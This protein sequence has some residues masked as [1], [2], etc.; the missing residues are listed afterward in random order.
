M[1]TGQKHFSYKRKQLRP[2]SLL[3]R[4]P[5]NLLIFGLCIS[6]AQNGNLEAKQRYIVRKP[7]KKRK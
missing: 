5:Y 1:E 4:F 2:P 3:L 6:S 7:E